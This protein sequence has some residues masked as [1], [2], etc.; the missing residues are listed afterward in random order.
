M[1][2]I[3]DDVDSQISSSIDASDPVPPP[4]QNATA[5]KSNS[6]FDQVDS[7]ANTTQPQGP[8]RTVLGTLGDVAGGVKDV[9]KMLYDVPIQT[10]GAIGGLL[11]DDDPDAR[12]TF[13]DEW[14]RA[15]KQRTEQRAAE[16]SPEDRAKKVFP[17]PGF[18]SESGAITR[19]D[20]QD[21]SASTGFSAVAMGAGFAG[22]TLGSAVGLW[23][24]AGGALAGAGAAA[25]K[26]DKANITR[27]LIDVAEKTKGGRLTDEERGELLTRTEA[28]RDDHALWEAGPEAVGTALSLT[29]IGKIFK[30]AA[31]GAT[32][33][34]IGGIVTSLGGELS[35][36][37]ITQIGQN[38]AENE[39]GLGDGNPM[40]FS[41]PESYK[42][43][44]QEVG[45]S[46]VTLSGV[47]GGGGYVAGKGRGL[48]D[49]ALGKGGSE[50]GNLASDIANSGKD[51]DKDPLGAEVNKLLYESLN[52]VQ[53]SPDSQAAAELAGILTGSPI[54]TEDDRAQM[55]QAALEFYNDPQMPQDAKDRFVKEGVFEHL[56]IPVP[57]Q[58]NGYGPE[59]QQGYSPILPEGARDQI[60][61]DVLNQQFPEETRDLMWDLTGQAE[62][63]QGMADT[64]TRKQRFENLKQ[65]LAD[66]ELS[67]E[68]LEANRTGRPPTAE[69]SAQ[70][71]LGQEP[72]QAM[73]D[74]E[75]RQ[76]RLEDAAAGF[77]A[78][79][80]EETGAGEMSQKDVSNDQPQVTQV[81]Q[82]P[83]TGH[84]KKG[85][86]NDIELSQ[87]ID[88]TQKQY[89]ETGREQVTQNGEIGHTKTTVD[90][91]DSIAHGKDVNL[92]PTEAQKE[93]ENYKTPKVSIDGLK[94]SIENPAGSVRSGKDASGKEWSQEMKADY[95]RILGSKGFDKDHVDIMVAPGYQ[96]GA[97]NVYVVNQHKADGSFDEHKILAGVNSEQEA[98]ALYNSNYEE[99]WA[100]GKSVT[101]VAMPVFKKW[102]SGRGP[103]Q[104]AFVRERT[105]FPGTKTPVAETK[106]PVSG[107]ATGEKS[108]YQMTPEEY[109]A[110][111]TDTDE[112]A[113]RLA[114][115]PRSVKEAL[116]FDLPVPLPVLQAYSN[117]QWAKN[118]IAKLYPDQ[119]VPAGNKS[120]T[121]TDKEN[122]SVQSD[123]PSAQTGTGSV[124]DGG[125]QL[126][127]H[128]T[129]K[130]K[131]IR[132]VVRADI[133]WKEAKTIDKFTFKK[134]GGWFIREQYLQKEQ[135]SD[136]GTADGRDG[137]G[138]PGNGNRTE[139]VSGLDT[140]GN[141][142][143]SGQSRVSK[144]GV[145]GEKLAQGETRLTAT[146][147]QTTPFPKVATDSNRKAKNTLKR[148][149]RWL[150]E[151]A[152]A[153]AEARG[154]EY[155][156]RMFR[157]NLEKPS[158][159]DKD[160]AEMYLFD[161]V[162]PKVTP[163]ILKDLVTPEQK[164]QEGVKQA[165]EE[166]SEAKQDG[167][168]AQGSPAKSTLEQLKEMS[169]DDI[170]NL[171]DE[172]DQERAAEKPPKAAS[173][174]KPPREPKAPSVPRPP[175]SNPPIPPEPK[176][177]AG[178][179]VKEGGIAAQ[180]AVKDA[181]AGLTALFGDPN[182]IRMGPA[183]DEET[184]RKAKPHFVNAWNGVKD[185]GYSVKELINYFYGQFGD[186]IRPYLQR[187]VKDVRNGNLEVEL[188]EKPN[189]STL[190]ERGGEPYADNENQSGEGKSVRADDEAAAGAG[191]NALE[192]VAAEGSGGT[193]SGRAPAGGSAQGGR[194]NAGGNK[195]PDGGRVP[196]PRG[197]RGDAAEVYPPDTGAGSGRGDGKRV[198]GPA[199]TPAIN[200]RITEDVRL[201][202]GGETVKFNDNLAA[203]KILKKLESEK[204]RATPEEQRALARYVGWGGLA[205]SF[206]NGVTGEVKSGW[207][208]RVAELEKILTPE[209]LAVARNSTKA[210]HYTSFPVVNAMWKAVERMGFK[211]GNVLE[212]S[213]GVGNFLG[214]MPES[215]AGN[216]NMMAV[217]Y[218][219]ITAGIAKHLYP[220]AA[221]FHSGFQELPLPENS[222]DLV[223]GNP[224]FG[225][226]R[227]NFPH[228]P[229]LNPYSIH[230]QFFLAGMDAL[231]PGGL[232]VM[233]VSRYLMDGK[234]TTVRKLLAGK[235]K[236]LAA[237]RL[238]DTAFKENAKTDVVTD[239]L[240]LQKYTEREL[241]VIETA[242]ETAAKQKITLP[243]PEWVETTT[244]P[245][246]LG[247]D[248][249]RVNAYFKSNP[250]AIIGQ[251]ERSGSM[252]GSGTNVNVKLDKSEDIAA[253]LD[254]IIRTMPADIAAEVAPAD[255][256]AQYFKNM[257]DAMKIS[258]SGQEL[259]S[260]SFNEFGE[261]EQVIDRETDGGD[262][263]L[264]KRVITPSSPWS[265]ALSMDKDG[266]W[267]RD[268]DKVDEKGEK[269][270]VVVGDKATKRNQKTREVFEKESDI[271]ANMKL[272]EPGYNRLRDSIQL[273]ETLAKQINLETSDSSEK[274]MESNRAKL[275]RQYDAYVKEHS[276]INDKKTANILAGMPNSA[277]LLSLESKY[278]PPIDKD[279][280]KKLG[281]APQPAMVEQ[282]TILSKRVISPVEM[283]TTAATPA[284]ALAINLSESGRID[285]ARVAE[286][287]G[288]SEEDTVKALHDDLDTPLI[289][290]D[291][292]TDRWEPADEYLGG[293]VVRKMEA[294]KDKGLDKNAKAL[295]KVLPEPWTADKVTATI[296]GVWIPADVYA[297]FLSHLTKS[298]S[299]V[300]YF[301]TT[302]TF[303]VQGR[304]AGPSNWGTQQRSPVALVDAILN[305]R[306]IK[307][308]YTDHEGKTHVDQEATDAAI[309]K[310]A[311]IKDE[312]DAWVFKDSDRRNRLVKIFNDKF[313]V[314]VTKQRDGQHL[315][316]PGKVPDTII[317][318]RRHQK[319]AI[320]RGIVDNVVLFDHSVGSGKTFTS[321]ARALE[322]KRMGLSRKPMIVVPNHLV[323]QF[324]KDVYKLYPGAKLLAAGKSDL[325]PAKRR[326]IFAKIATGDWD[327]V[328]VPHSSFQFIG[329]S[330]ATETRY[331]EAEL[332][333]AEE[334]VKEALAETGHDGGNFRK[335]LAVKEAEALRDKIKNRLAQVKEKSG[336]KD[337]LLTFE[338]LGVDDL[339]IDE[340][341]EFK[342]LFYNSSLNVRGMGPKGGSGK[343]YDMWTKTRVLHEMPNGSVAFMT[344]TPISNSAVEMYTL[345]RYLVPDLL[346]EHG[347]EHFD[348]WRNNFASVNSAFEPTD[349]G[350]GLK[351]V[352]RLGRDWTNTRSLM[353]LYYTFAD[354]VSNDDIQKWYAEDNNGAQFPLPKVKGGGRVGI[355]VKPT[356]AQRGIIEDIISGFDGLESISDPKERNKARLRLMDRARK[357]SLDARAARP[358]I[359]SN[360]E[361]GKLSRVSDE[362]VRLHRKWT[363]E[364]G[365]QLIFL[366]RSV[367]KA[368]GDDKIIKTYDEL[369]AKLEAA[370]RTGDEAAIRRI[371]DSLERFDPVEIEESRT[372]Q[373]GGWNAYQ[374]IK[375]NLVE[376]GI[377][378]N[379]IR[380]IQEADTDE[381]KK[382]LFEEVNSGAVRV[383]IGSTPRMGA[384]TN[385]Q[386]RLVG[387]HHVDV[388]WKPSDIE[389]R[390][391]RIIR[392]GNKIGF[393]EN[394]NSIRDDFEVEILA[395]TTDTTVDA[396]MW[397]L[398]STKLKMI[399]GIRQY[400]GSFTMEFD[401]TDAVGMAEIAAIASGEPLQ[402]ERVQ[403]TAEIDKLERLKRAHERQRWAAEDTIHRMER[404]IE[405]ALAMIKELEAAAK[406]VEKATAD[407]RRKWESA[408]VD[409]DGTTYGGSDARKALDKLIEESKKEGAEPFSVTI[410]GKKYRA[411]VK[412]EDA[413]H[414]VLGD[415]A[416][417]AMKINGKSFKQRGEA[418]KEVVA[419]ANAKLEQIEKQDPDFSESDEIMLGTVTVHGI[420]IDLSMQVSMSA[421]G[422]EKHKVVDRK[423][424]VEFFFERRVDLPGG[425][426]SYLVNQSYASTLAANRAHTAMPSLFRGTMD[427][428]ED[429]SSRASNEARLL[430]TAEKDL[431]TYK[432][433]AEKP[434]AKDDELK[435]K[436][437]RLVE[438]ERELNNRKAAATNQQ[439]LN[440]V[441][442]TAQKAK[443]VVQW[444]ADN[445]ENASYRVI[446]NKIKD[447]IGDDIKLTIVKPGEKV[448]GGVPTALNISYGVYH[449]ELKTG[450]KEIF[451]KHT[452]FGEDDNGMSEKVALH[453]LIHAATLERITAGN[454][455]KNE[456][457]ALFA[458][459]QELY[460]LQNAVVDYLNDR[461]KAG[462]QTDF[463]KKLEVQMA[464]SDVHELV[465]WG[466]TSKEFQQML[467]EIPVGNGK[468]GFSKFI[469]TLLSL[470]G[471]DK[472]KHNALSELVKITESILDSQGLAPITRFS[473]SIGT[474]TGRTVAQL[475]EELRG[476]IGE[477]AFSSLVE[478]GAV[479]FVGT[480][481]E[482]RAIID[483]LNGVQESAAWHGSPHSFDKFSTAAIGTGEGNQAYG[484]G[485]Y[486]AGSKK[487]AEW[488]KTRLARYSRG[489][490]RAAIQY[491]KDEKISSDPEE[492]YGYSDDNDYVVLAMLNGFKP[493]DTPTGRLY[494]VELAPA[495]DEYLLWD[496]PL[497]EQSEKVKTALR[498]AGIE[499]KEP[500]TYD[501]ET[502]DF[503]DDI[504]EGGLKEGDTA[505][506]GY[507]PTGKIVYSRLSSESEQ[508]ASEYLH[509]LGIRGIK[510]LDGT[511]RG[512][513]DGNFNYVIFNDADVSIVDVQYS[514]DGRTIQGFTDGTKSWLVA[515]GIQ[516]GRAGDVLNHE[517]GVHLRKLMLNDRE[518]Q[519][520]E[521]S[522]PKRQRESGRTGRAIRA[523]MARVPK[524]TKSE[525][526]WSEVLAYMV[527]DAPESGVVRRIMAAAK[528]I[529]IRV[530]GNRFVNYLSV[531]DLK[532]M[533]IS[534]VKR[535]G[536]VRGSGNPQFSFAGKNAAAA[537]TGKLAEAQ[538]MKA[539]GKPREDIW[540]ETGWWEI[541]PGQWSFELDDSLSS[542]EMLDGKL[543]DVL[544]DRGLFQAYPFLK[545][546]NIAFRS[547]GPNRRG[548]FSPQDVT[549]YVNSRMDNEAARSTVHHEIQHII[550]R[551]EGFAGGTSYKESPNNSY[552]RQA[553]EVE[554]RLVQFRRNM[555][556][557]ARKAQPPWVSMEKMLKA[558]GLLKDGQDVRDVLLKRPTSPDTLM[559]S[560]QEARNTTILNAQVDGEVSNASLSYGEKLVAK[561]MRK[562]AAV[563]SPAVANKRFK[564]K[565]VDE[566]I[567]AFQEARKVINDPLKSAAAKQQFA[568]VFVNKLP[569][570]PRAKLLNKL[571]QIS[572]VKDPEKQ[573]KR[574]RNFLTG[575]N[576]ALTEWLK[577][578]MVDKMEKA[579]NPLK[580]KKGR[581][582]QGRG[583]SFERDLKY[584]R[585]TAFKIGTGSSDTDIEMEIEHERLVKERLA[586]EEQ[587]DEAK[588][589]KERMDLEEKLADTESFKNLLSI[590]GGIEAQSFDEVVRAYRAMADFLEEGRFP[591]REKI[592]ALRKRNKENIKQLLQVVTGEEEPKP[593]TMAKKRQREVREKSYLGK[594]KEAFS[595]VSNSIQS[596]EILMDIISRKSGAKT[597]QSWA[598]KHYGSIV[599]KATRDE[600][601]IKMDTHEMILE[602]AVE[603][604]GVK[605]NVKLAKEFAKLSQQ[606][607]NKVFT[608]TGENRQSMPMSP[609]EAAYW[610]QISRGIDNPN[611]A[612]TFESMG[613]TDET[614][615]QIEEL[616]GPKLKAWADYLVSE[617]YQD[618]H[619]DSNK[620]YRMLHGIDL[621]KTANYVPLH[622]E[623]T[624]K[625]ADKEKE[626][627]LARAEKGNI[628]KGFTR[629]RV[630]TTKHFKVM[631]LNDVLVNHI[632]DAAHFRAWAL[633]TKEINGT[634]NSP[635]VQKFI[636]QH[637]GASTMRTIRR[638]QDRFVRSD[639]EIADDLHF[640]DKVRGNVTRAMVGLNPVV[641]LK[642]LT[643]LPSYMADIPMDAWFKHT[644]Y[645]LRHP[646]MVARILG[647]ST[648]IKARYQQGFERDV[649][650]AMKLGGNNVV[651]RHRRLTDSVMVLVQ[652]GDK[653]SVLMGGYA[654]YK[655]HL[656]KLKAAGVSH[657]EADKQAL[658]EF[659]MATER[660]QQSGAAK[661]LGWF[662]SGT[663]IMKLFTM[664]M[665]APASYS[666]QIFMAVRNM[667]ADP[668]DSAKR[669]FVFGVLMPVIFQAIADA[670]MIFGGDDDDEERFWKNQAK[671]LALG[672]F[673]GLPIIRTMIEGYAQAI[674]G[675][676]FHDE[677][678][679]VAEAF[680][681][682]KETVSDFFKFLQ[683]GTE[684]IPE[685]EYLERSL[686]GLVHT[687]GYM[688]GVP[689]KPL[690]RTYSGVYDAATGETEHPIRRVIGYSKYVV[691]ENE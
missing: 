425:K 21:T 32:Q 246:P 382:F 94:L 577:D 650:T 537:D 416:F 551:H 511:S 475:E 67:L 536:D 275:R 585:E 377:P 139:P 518:Y 227:L 604:F 146:G 466:L 106:A 395:Y 271:P 212:P 164:A 498:K 98:L 507:N 435:Q 440:D 450:R 224:P 287:L 423:K 340:S 595:A 321:I 470:F 323:E 513:G 339:T 27:Q 686:L 3:F 566:A 237:I 356:P 574:L 201:G 178:Q 579:V 502:A 92:A 305:N 183:F 31:T 376:R 486:F 319:N 565:A 230:H 351:E 312:F 477:E 145:I 45:P 429:I 512:K 102:V 285:L 20:I 228:N 232:Q 83:E 14:Q 256:Q 375:D 128:V 170:D 191:D 289:F 414:A 583:D 501:K 417:F 189:K 335:P 173:P 644:A 290:F 109:T 2:N 188:T 117:N 270:K 16:L 36:E 672:P 645:A 75:G 415:A 688:T 10:K 39:M 55:V 369:M 482:A 268:V 576:K 552:Y 136:S 38:I 372:A 221:V 523:A 152:L 301:R 208:D 401:D 84:T 637:Y 616:M 126:V 328:I 316:F 665:T 503:F 660:S 448:E 210:A 445:A 43:A 532:A 371:G 104:G 179:I 651:A 614:L 654:V 90:N 689:T 112:K 253:R 329:I 365:T 347:L 4:V 229:D 609:T 473:K 134:D 613:V 349:S 223:I 374:Q 6:A 248:P 383:L 418:T 200:F 396:K 608:G 373:A 331:L 671:A 452:D 358:G 236:L 345:M 422:Y 172:V 643:A 293:N 213:V 352:S 610:Y 11:E 392:Q 37:T 250:A 72:T 481:E 309:A 91:P 138:V 25:Y 49:A 362:V 664:F 653:V 122:L 291:P 264:S 252:R 684:R 161:E 618:F 368:K 528:K 107:T 357:V 118:G 496:K 182:T 155:N 254:K 469:D 244:I 625:I 97:D 420:D 22:G 51:L 633:P 226:D 681:T 521:R 101:R 559:F 438:V 427:T 296:G 346:E 480:Q 406:T 265:S 269:V 175:K 657:R 437:E 245:D 85:S 412:A 304:T 263:I 471:I 298:P 129:K 588:T 261:L 272:G 668:K 278:K 284:D 18:L 556:P 642:Q 409:I 640:L 381:K 687:F 575:G 209:E 225:Q 207:E 336:K 380:F 205:N 612:K 426:Q 662:Q 606:V 398:N 673:Q 258:L 23:G 143:V 64:R 430:A 203:I 198:G 592:E 326:R 24:T 504:I 526:Y 330:P 77:E 363:A 546:V 42:K 324:A 629:A 238:P 354:C 519:A 133:T 158:Q 534:A 274:E 666:R 484:A 355:N 495:E 656:D 153:E 60:D 635:T 555:T 169:D 620:I 135:T 634:F 601:R 636:R 685:D 540:E 408:T 283:A 233:V 553:G 68:E 80:P 378:A 516:K 192:G 586:I 115:H 325:V 490:I 95:G 314:R 184:Y 186:K 485:L 180:S 419:L 160:S 505:N 428:I 453:E 442:S 53:E 177:T 622:R 531:D 142:P 658:E 432:E 669:L 69:E 151:N 318:M 587:I 302:N 617:F 578:Q 647:R 544:K 522:L 132:G 310:A 472:N 86:K 307:V 168:K 675:Q 242:R 488:Y 63:E 447:H 385:V 487:V 387:L 571:S 165:S 105:V 597:L 527:E 317:A 87:V 243:D 491:L 361:G 661:D 476:T 494:Q 144:K 384:G 273:L 391:G 641:F 525:H 506:D 499:T 557:A 457:T 111:I 241:S 116:R 311:E 535:G 35:T 627:M 195:K 216:T 605:D 61:A 520:I 402:L 558:E 12:V 127:E 530:F 249:M 100:G 379:E 492:D 308:T 515:D 454:L 393:D 108:P 600:E 344:G 74:V 631:N 181:M 148:V 113:I 50:D 266:K 78:L 56:G 48:I 262:T 350:R 58:E 670:L 44:L 7:I 313:N 327:M 234:D 125:P 619:G 295:E 199:T 120:A 342:N 52:G 162:Q 73:A 455:M 96:G 333:I 193:G 679:P 508:A 292:E 460:G 441:L 464:A 589:E 337:R 141:A 370:E 621:D 62:D 397:T 103:S 569:P 40:S 140:T 211:G 359:D 196:A 320:W 279:K 400:D 594:I 691:G 147:R 474:T 678:T 449:V 276:H 667:K 545:G 214:L 582:K 79:P 510:Y 255:K 231:K 573:Q 17:L 690:Q 338:Q 561:I 76:A 564:G 568:A 130:G 163:S 563:S 5:G 166:K 303:H 220:N 542:L 332:A 34:I 114:A 286:L 123:V 65:G 322:R 206:R 176:K 124:S 663:P 539:A 240:F 218:D 623:V 26:M 489:A 187:F 554:A 497:S 353:D 13:A 47:M 360:E 581:L 343:A 386:E 615:D 465:T 119:A 639:R 190:E 247:G 424:Q 591:W 315:Q 638:F 468:T 648:M 389:Q 267:F 174:P 403:L 433:V 456:G 451:L 15:A 543:S 300:K 478:S 156:A 217:E 514:E 341:H 81:T 185:L 459:I 306:P 458:A 288:K 215:L 82:N 500:S 30:G 28:V 99:G 624:G 159:A 367:P 251:L 131:T 590:F 444:L 366:D 277:L 550:Q 405:T 683:G 611:I 628:N 93:A 281:I 407:E 572:R 219:N 421:V 171:F 548:I 676:Y 121:P 533:A 364:K 194:K 446:A 529:L 411:K 9:G 29:G 649:A 461:H 547:L 260:I 150:M 71:F 659:E 33:K 410:D 632:A 682:S 524:S 110:G 541:V 257:V 462:T 439:N 404:T 239:V 646:V 463:E 57:L 294:A 652:L 567:E 626:G 8:E 41:D 431:P 570:V 390:E 59:Q 154:D 334:A 222:F 436:G 603:I 677:F 517:V 259:G 413:L 493:N 282:A 509:S 538:E 680:S 596:W 599:H 54:E 197:G 394:G 299:E 235:G 280:A 593:E 137:S 157:R 674:N 46:V 88:T 467:A 89:T 66:R 602:K 204:R 202:Q 167:E 1:G 297:D 19:G 388:T 562:L 630:A 348:A 149:D 483:R 434:F 399:N 549:I 655:H 560:Y 580:M 479:D 70:A 607:E 443:D 584:L 598:V